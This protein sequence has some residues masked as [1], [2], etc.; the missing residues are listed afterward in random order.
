M[1]YVSKLSRNGDLV[2]GVMGRFGG[3]QHKNK[4]KNKKY[5]KKLTV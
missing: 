5:I 2:D 4:N 3:L 1:R